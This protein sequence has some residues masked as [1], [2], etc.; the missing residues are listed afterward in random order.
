MILYIDNREPKS[1][2][3]YINC[4]NDNSKIKIDIQIKALD[5]GDYLIADNSNNTLVI[6]ER[7]SL[8]DL[9]C[10]IKDGRYD[11]QSFR[12]N[13]F[14]LVNHNIYYLIEGNI[15]NYRNDKFKSTLYSSLVSLSYYKGFSILNSV[16]NVESAEIVY[17]FIKKLEKEINNNKTSFYKNDN[18]SKVLDESNDLNV[19]KELD[20]INVIKTNKKSNITRDN[21][22]I[23]MLMQIPGINT[24]TSTTI[25]EKFETIKNLVIELEKDNTCLDCIK[26]TSSNRKISK[27]I[28]EN[29]K[30]YLLNK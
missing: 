18:I 19:S 30:Y 11:E 24:Q 3:N 27:N 6:I 9:E 8:N 21:I 16:N 15:I 5:I 20:Y 1:I 7:K 29:I 25:I 2:I 4:L 23:I 13:N 17:N 26:I 10:S 22:N 14:D 28:I 12:L